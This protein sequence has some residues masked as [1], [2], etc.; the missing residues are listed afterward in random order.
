MSVLFSSILQ[1]TFYLRLILCYDFVLVKTLFCMPSD[2]VQFFL[3]LF[4][5]KTLPLSCQVEL[6]G[7]KWIAI[8]LMAQIL[9]LIHC[10]RF[11][12]KN[13]FNF[14]LGFNRNISTEIYNRNKQIWNIWKLISFIFLSIDLIFWIRDIWRWSKY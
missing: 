3:W 5:W 11:I 8:D 10:L 4:R 6:C 1:L 7:G 14:L 13:K 2:N 12:L 9:I